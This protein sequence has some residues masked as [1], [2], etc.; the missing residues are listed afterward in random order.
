LNKQRIGIR[1]IASRAAEELVRAREG[2]PQWLE[3]H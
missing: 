1:G 2:Q 3:R